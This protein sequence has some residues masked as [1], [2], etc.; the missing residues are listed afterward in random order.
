VGEKTRWWEVGWGFVMAG[1]AEED[2]EEEGGGTEEEGPEGVAEGTEEEEEGVGGR[3]SEGVF[4]QKTLM[5]RLPRTASTERRARRAS[6]C[7]ANCT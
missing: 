2:E 3:E 5:K 6:W 1:A 4:D 7:V